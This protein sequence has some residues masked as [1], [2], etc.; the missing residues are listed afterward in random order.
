MLQRTTTCFLLVFT[1][2]CILYASGRVFSNPGYDKRSQRSYQENHPP[3]VKIVSPV[4]NESY[5]WGVAIPYSVRVSDKEDGESQY[6]EI[7]ANEVFLEVRSL[8][9]PPTQAA[10]VRSLAE[11]DPRGL[12]LIKASN[13]LN[14][15][16]QRDKLIGPSFAEIGTRYT[17][18]TP[19][20]DLLSKHIREGSKGVWGSVVMPTH[21]ELTKEEATAMVRWILQKSKQSD[22]DFYKGIEGSIRLKKPRDPQR[23]TFLLIASYTDHGAK[24]HTGKKMTGQDAIIVKGR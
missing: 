21:P 24:D 6:D 16:T 14:C 4:M 22:V 13:C 8:R 9:V 11:N 18:T 10:A 19:N 12:T 7:P 5:E 1:V 23:N 20:V 15:H 3:E 17:Y 2:S